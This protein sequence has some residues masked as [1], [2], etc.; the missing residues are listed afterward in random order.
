MPLNDDRERVGATIRALREARG[1]SRTALAGAV[2]IS[3]SHLANIENGARPC[4]TELAHRL[5]RALEVQIKAITTRC[6]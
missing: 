5:A 4:T 2:E 1:K 6:D 3:A